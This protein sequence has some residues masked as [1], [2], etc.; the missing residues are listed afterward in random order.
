MSLSESFG[1]DDSHPARLIPQIPNAQLRTSRMVYSANT[2][3][4]L[5]DRIRWAEESGEVPMFVQ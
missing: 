1:P 3:P 2:A 5:N 4:E